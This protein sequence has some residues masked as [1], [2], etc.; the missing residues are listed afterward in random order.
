MNISYLK[1]KIFRLTEYT[2]TESNL[3]EKHIHIPNE[4]SNGIM[5]HFQSKS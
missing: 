2:Q 3:G 5:I 1:F 4:F